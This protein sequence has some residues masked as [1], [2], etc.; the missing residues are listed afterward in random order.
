MGK[1]AERPHRVEAP[2]ADFVKDSGQATSCRI[3]RPS[4][5]EL[6]EL[7]AAQ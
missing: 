1:C 3:I 7:F 2:K 5:E 4:L 6:V